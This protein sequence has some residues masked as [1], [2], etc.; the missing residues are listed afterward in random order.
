[1]K[2]KFILE[3]GL[4]IIAFNF[5]AAASAL[6]QETLDPDY[7]Y[8]D[9]GAVLWAVDGQ[10]E[11]FKELEQREDG[12]T[13]GIES[14][15]YD[16]V[17]GEDW[18]LHFTG[19]LVA[20]KDA[21]A[22][23][24]LKQT[25]RWKF[26]VGYNTYR[27]YGNNTVESYDF[28][29][30][31]NQL[32]R[33]MELDRGRAY[34]RGELN[35]PGLPVINLG[36]EQRSQ[37]GH[38]LLM[39]RGEVDFLSFRNLPG[40]QEVDTD[41][42][43]ANLAVRH[44]IAGVDVSFSQELSFFQG[45]LISTKNRYET[46]LGTIKAEEGTERPDTFVSTSSLEL[47]RN[48]RDNLFLSLGYRFQKTDGE[49]EFNKSVVDPI[50]GSGS[51]KL[52]GDS[53][54]DIDNHSISFGIRY[55]PLEYL[56]LR[57]E[58]GYQN[59]EKRGTADN[60]HFSP[61]DV[62][63]TWEEN[64]SDIND[65]NMEGN[66]EARFS[67]IPRTTIDAGVELSRTKREYDERFT[68]GRGFFDDYILDTDADLTR[69]G[70]WARMRVRPASFVHLS[71]RY[72]WDRLVVDYDDAQT[73]SRGSPSGIGDRSQRR[74]RTDIQIRLTPLPILSSILTFREERSKF[75][76]FYDDPDE[77]ANTHVRTYGAGFTLVPRG[78]LTFSTQYT[79]Q[80]LWAN[81]RASYL[82]DNVPYESKVHTWF[83]GVEITLWK[84]TRLFL[85]SLF[86]RNDGAG[87]NAGGDGSLASMS[88]DS[89]LQSYGL[90]V[91]HSL[92]K[93]ASVK[94]A[95]RYMDLDAEEAYDHDDFSAY[96]FF[97]RLRI[98]MP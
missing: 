69:T 46:G 73:I 59:L 13:G 67:V 86:S 43:V 21:Y 11:K 78:W 15:G 87:Q 18:L 14:L 83:N 49:G 32:S 97:V 36:Y 26:D 65:R 66:L 75:F 7:F 41:E 89:T 96:M 42:H 56:T 88:M 51:L 91:E 84:G 63:I 33:S 35:R 3:L 54:V 58:L 39:E 9:S 76:G 52:D 6:G 29:P 80:D 22:S 23:V 48:I 44:T 25:D 57:G 94:A 81:T 82:P 8:A 38:R 71:A 19:R 85:D 90:A 12:L 77:I 40:F 20:E 31:D 34:I 60:Q 1:M 61:R 27:S 16:R 93:Q 95:V 72:G 68:S 2:G 92:F 17:L 98:D 28:G 70:Y 45:S 5:L 4:W 50:G 74:G 37:N 55:L 24:I 47:S 62:F 79:Y 64:R 30:R 53:D 10:E